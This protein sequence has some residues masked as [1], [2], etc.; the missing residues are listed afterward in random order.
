MNTKELEKCLHLIGYTVLHTDDSVMNELLHEIDPIRTY[1]DPFNKELNDNLLSKETTQGKTDMIKHYIFELWEL[2]ELYR[3]NNTILRNASLANGQYVFINESDEKKQLTD[4]E[5]YIVESNFEFEMMF[6]C[7]QY[8]CFKYCIDF[9]Q[10]CNEL[11]FPIE[12]FDTAVTVL[13]TEK[14]GEGVTLGQHEMKTGKYTAKHY[15]L[16]YYFDCLAK[17]NSL[18]IGNKKKLELI[19]KERIGVKS[20]NTFYKNFTAII[21]KVTNMDENTLIQIGGTEW[22]KIV[23]E[24]STAPEQVEQYLNS[25]NYKIGRK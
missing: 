9:F 13:F 2:Q 3:E 1:I 16:A 17:G 11:K 20:G 7:I 4:W 18:P 19:G 24:L 15:V 25:N 6:D 5:N 12:Y 8:C 10:V 21:P 14:E 23:L 22:R